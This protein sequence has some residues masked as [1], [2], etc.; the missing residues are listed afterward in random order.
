M[1][2]T[3]AILRVF[4]H[5]ARRYKGRVVAITLATLLAVG[6]DM[7]APWFLKALIDGF[8]A[9]GPTEQV[10][11]GL[12]FALFGLAMLRVIGWVSWRV[13]GFI[14]C[15]FQPRVMADLQQTSLHYLLGH[16]YSFFANN[17]SGSLVRK[18]HR[19]SRAFE[20]LADE[21]QFRFIP[22]VVA[23]IGTGIGLALRFPPLAWIFVAWLLVYVFFIYLAAR[24]TI[25]M[26]IKRAEVDSEATGTIS[27]IITNAVTVKL[28]PG[29]EVE[30]TT[31][32][33]V[34]SR[35]WK[36]QRRSWA[37]GE[38]TFTI[39]GA[40]SIVI[41]I[42]LLW[43]GIQQW[44]N[45]LLTGG[46]LVLIQTYLML[47]FRQ[48]WD[49]SRG[50]RHVSESVADAEEMVSILNTPYEVMDR[51]KIKSFRVS[52]GKIEFQD[53]S[54]SFHKTRRVLEHFDL[55]IKAREKV[56]LV[57]P[58]GAGKSTITRLLLR[59]HD[60]QE[61]KILIDGQDISRVSQDA[62]RDMIAF[63]PQDPILFHRT[64]KD[65]IGYGR[66]GATDAEIMAAAKK[67]H[68]D[69]FIRDLPNQY[70]TFVGERGIKLSGGERQRVAIARAILKDAP[71]LVLDEATSSLDSA[72]E[73]LIQDALR[74]LMQNKSAIIIAH[75]LSTIMNMDRII[76]LD[77]GRVVDMGAH[78]ELLRRTGTYQKLWKIQA[79]GFIST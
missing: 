39:Q 70:E 43:I 17:F 32:R 41:E 37:R 58:S 55:S 40:L 68:C 77:Q 21:I 31:C 78:E 60:V 35:W 53:V 61:G 54:F 2:N 12:F 57:G 1:V 46:D 51:V 56:A 38:W 50:F 47:V 19:L 79:G 36:L 5:H 33:E 72:S 18:V 11:R 22:I 30:M 25:A 7:V 44:Q 73:S 71:I 29:R 65:N 23:V 63:V 59:L 28:F 3:Q 6:V 4:W 34:L 27:D 14:T 24:W 62:L 16:S 52:R 45:G 69:E 75:R 13:I 9:P 64:L 8:S 26:D 76:V 74:E 20:T 15:D 66:R 42:T 49:M 10:M 48:L 67:A